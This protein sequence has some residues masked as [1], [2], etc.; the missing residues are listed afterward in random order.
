MRNQF[1]FILLSLVLSLS[2]HSSELDSLRQ[3]LRSNAHDSLKAKA[4]NELGIIISGTDSD[5]AIFLYKKGITLARSVGNR[6]VEGG[7]CMNLGLA[8][9]WAGE[10]DDCRKTLNQG[11][12]SYKTAGAKKKLSYAYFI[13]GT[14]EMNYH[15]YKEGGQNLLLALSEGDSIQD[16]EDVLGAICN[17]LGLVYSYYGEH[18]KSIS[19]QIKAIEFKKASGNKELASSMLNLGMEYQKMNDIPNAEKY[20]LE[21][22]EMLG[23]DTSATKANSLHVMG[24]MYLENHELDK[25][26][27]C[28]D[29]LKM[30]AD[31]LDDSTFTTYSYLDY[32]NLATDRGLYKKALPLFLKAFQ[33]KPRIRNKRIDQQLNLDFASYHKSNA[34]NTDD[35]EEQMESW[36]KAI[37]YAT[38]GLS[39][40]KELGILE[41]QL[42]ALSILRETYEGIGDKDKALAYANEFINANDSFFSLE[43]QKVAANL[44]F[45]YETEKKELEIELLNKDNALQ[46]KEL[47]ESAKAQQQQFYV[48]LGALAVLLLSLSI[49]VLLLRQSRRRKK[50]NAQLVEQNATIEKQKQQVENALLEITKRDEEKE[51]LLKEIH[52]RVKNNLQVVSSLLDL[53]S[54]KAG[55]GEKAA[56]AEGQSRVR[57]MALIHEKLYQSKTISEIDFEAYCKQLSQQI[58]QLYGHGQQVDCQIDVGDIKLDIDTAVPVGLILNELVTNAYKYAFTKGG[59][60][61]R[62]SAEKDQQNTYTL[63]IEDTGEGLPDDFDWRKSKSL[64][65]RL[66]HRLARQLYGTA[67]YSK[68]DK[69]MFEITFKDTI[70]RKA[71]A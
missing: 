53:Q 15:N 45:E 61:L 64:G 12:E 32:A 18:A 71:I 56:L 9:G 39:Q 37:H 31:V 40:T 11:I 65:L 25:A 27:K 59:G 36:Q 17:N 60:R 41:D 2:A 55:D 33:V 48:I 69:S 66:V 52:H 51:L 24:L 28:F 7:L 43:K 13:A 26:Q 44:Q 19:Y 50:V 68:S 10:L 3:V 49:A 1:I 62:I 46:V 47:A 5:S 38:I 20:F 21:G 70:E 16:Y 42:K 67:E 22:H 57:A 29:E 34:Q 54:K 6:I 14:M 8:Y 23:D 58:A 4:Y 35:S 30:V 63:R